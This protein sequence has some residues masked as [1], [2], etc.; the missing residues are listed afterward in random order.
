MLPLQTEHCPFGTFQL[1]LQE[2][3][4]GRSILRKRSDNRKLRELQP[5]FTPF[6]PQLADL[7]GFAQVD[8]SSR[9]SPAAVLKLRQLQLHSFQ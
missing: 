7:L 8:K 2:P 1:R 3:P 6:Q 5:G 9:S 4:A